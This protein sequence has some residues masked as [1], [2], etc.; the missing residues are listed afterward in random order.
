VVTLDALH[1]VKDQ[2]CWLVQEKKAHCI[3]VIEGNQPI[4]SAQVKAL[5]WEQVPVAHTVS[6]TGHGRR[7]SRSVKTMAIAANPG[8]TAFPQARLALRIHR[9]RKESGKRQTGDSALDAD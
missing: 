2:V 5:P 4:A 9:R 3:A 6:G 8:G 7:E 1:S